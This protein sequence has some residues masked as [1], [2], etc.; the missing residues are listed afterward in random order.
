MKKK[1]I[2]VAEDDD[3]DADLTVRALGEFRHSHE[4]VISK[5]GASTLD[6]LRRRGNYQERGQGSPAVVLLDLK[7]PKVDGMEVLR[8]IKGDPDL[9][10]IPVVMLTSSRHVVDVREC[11]RAGANGYIVKPMDF[12]SYSSILQSFARY[13]LLVNESA[14]E[15]ATAA[16]HAKR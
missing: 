4:I 1:W 15:V 2:L 9:Q 14:P 16:P 8:A 3:R 5:D 13:W 7:M 11:Y 6:H 10:I 12:H